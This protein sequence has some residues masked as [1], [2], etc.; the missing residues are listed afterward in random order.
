MR[1]LNK[2]GFLLICLVALCGGL[3]A[4]RTAQAAVLTVTT[5]ASA[6]AG[7]LRAAVTSASPNDTI[8]FALA[9]ENATITLSTQ[10]FI[11]KPL[12]IR[13]T[14]SGTITLNGGNA[15]RIIEFDPP[16]IT[17]RLVLSRLNLING[18]TVE[19]FG[20]AAIRMFAVLRLNECNFNNNQATGS[21]LA[22]GGAVCAVGNGEIDTADACTFLNNSAGVNGG[23]VRSKGAFIS[24]T[25]QGNTAGSDGGAVN[26]SVAEFTF[27]Q[28]ISNTAGRYGGGVAKTSEGG[29]RLNLLFSTFNANSAGASGGNL[30]FNTQGDI[31]MTN[32]SLINGVAADSGGG[33][34][35]RRELFGLLT[36][37]TT[38]VSGN[39]AGVGGGACLETP[40]IAN[41]NTFTG[42]RA[43]TH[44]GALFVQSQ[45][46]QLTNFV[47][48]GNRAASGGGIFNRGLLRLDSSSVTADT[49]TGN[50]GGIFN[51]A[52]TLSVN[53]SIVR[54]NVAQGISGGGVFNQS[55]AT[56]GF[57]RSFINA[58][59]SLDEG[60]GVANSGLAT[61]TDCILTGNQTETSGGGLISYSGSA[62]TLVHCTVTNNEVT[63]GAG[64][65]LTNLG[66]SL[67][68]R[69]TV[70]VFNRAGSDANLA[71]AAAGTG[72]VTVNPAV[73][74]FHSPNSPFPLPSATA[75][76]GQSDQ[77]FATGTDF[78]NTPRNTPPTVGAL[79]A[80][81]ATLIPNTVAV[82]TASGGVF[83]GTLGDITLNLT[84]ITPATASFRVERYSGGRTG[85]IPTVNASPYFWT[86]STTAESLSG[87]LTLDWSA[88]PANGVA[89]A[90]T[91]RL[92]TREGFGRAW[93][94]IPVTN[95]AT[96]L[97][98]NS[99]SGFSE[100]ALGSIGDSPLPVELFSFTGNGAATG[101]ELK[102]T[103]AS[104]QSN[105]GFILYRATGAAP[106]QAA[107]IAH[108]TQ[109][110]QLQGQGTTSERTGYTYT[111][112]AVEAGTDYIYTLE[113]VDRSGTVHRYD[114]RVTARLDG[115]TAKAGRYELFQNYPNPFNP[116]T[117]I[118][119][120]MK[121]A[122]EAV[123]VVSDML[124]R[125]VSRETLNAKAGEN[126]YRLNGSKLT[127]GTY[128]Y[129]LTVLGSA[130][131][132]AG[133]SQT[134]KMVLVK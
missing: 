94:D 5:N 91:V 108:Y 27:C 86:V 36:M 71:N 132:R 53:S 116:T 26:A 123:V 34:F 100:F 99:V 16:I 124:G 78:L 11:D 64:G 21:F 45:D 82:G 55:G 118:R 37:N 23:A 69:N 128:F 88:V 105:A 120:T 122:G 4:P 107:V 19:D 87:S 79:E 74:P 24:C 14:L 77:T 35:F 22:F 28:L 41:R 70:S 52:G 97:T 96:S 54:L 63:S 17:Q 104:E 75:L 13:N 48:T 62:T 131:S 20:G 126:Q 61:L 125:T 57:N 9:L 84:G 8:V 110:P 133:F 1:H 49:A 65:G 130:G 46:A 47:V 73:Y 58:N 106:Q 113:S 42:N 39:Q 85:A 112:A 25:F 117:I 56:L 121:Q 109:V 83:S 134:K 81:P 44:G 30:Y 92:L 31:T 33:I 59:R 115:A 111:D 43:A 90:S 15:T 89:D 50:G 80:V 18:L 72:S 6:G 102:W 114:K 40:L 95:G 67:T 2:T 10:L 7:S 76:I 68:L 93:T 66:N 103:T 51:A 60:G 98:L 3:G 129:Q 32:C 38:T 12:T 119:F 127:S 101:V 29:G